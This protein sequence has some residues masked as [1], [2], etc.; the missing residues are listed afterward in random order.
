MSDKYR[1]EKY[2]IQSLM[3]LIHS[4]DLALPDFQRDF[5][6][7]PDATEELL[8][9]IFQEYP[10]GSLL[11]MRHRDDGFRPRQ[12]EGAPPLGS[13]R[14]TRLTLDGQ[15]RLTSLYQAFFGV[16]RHRYYLWLEKLESGATLEDCLTHESAEK[17]KKLGYETGEAQALNL[18]MPLSVVARDGFGAWQADV[19]KRRKKMDP[20]TDT[21]ALEERLRN[22]E[23]KWIRPIATYNYPY[24]E[25]DDTVSMVAICTIFETLNRTGIKLTVFELLAARMFAADMRLRDMWDKALHEY[26]ILSDFRVDPT[27]LLQVVALRAPAIA[28]CQRADLLRLTRR[29]ISDHWA[30]AVAGY[31]G[32]LEMLRTDCGV[33]IDRWLPYTVQVVPMAAVWDRVTSAK[34]PAVGANRLKLQ[35][36]F[37]NAAFRQVYEAGA[38]TRAKVDYDSLVAWFSNGVEPKLFTEPL[39]TPNFAAITPSQRALY[40]ATIALVIRHGATDFHK[41]QRLTPEVIRAQAIDDHHIFPKAHLGAGIPGENSVA[42]RTLIDKTTNIRIGKRAPSDYFGEISKELGAGASKLM[43][44]HLLPP[45]THTSIVLDDFSAFLEERTRRLLSEFSDAVSVPT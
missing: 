13:K 29:D 32:V 6:W 2:A 41:V 25:L 31:A 27:A 40:R 34:G 22:L 37:W 36:W 16:G 1:V 10:T 42:N 44:S 23:L 3:S 12:F 20:T 26:P 30:A 39:E 8:E 7:D 21:D 19:R 35:R 28:A 43:D 11:F 33:L 4:G 45:I 38:N 9:S 14:P 5:V 24:V 18:L 17:A 15:Q